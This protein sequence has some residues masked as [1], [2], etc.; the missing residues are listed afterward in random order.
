MAGFASGFAWLTLGM[1]FTEA[2]RLGWR[3]GV[4]R[5]DQDR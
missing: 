2:W 4:R 1:V 3:P 5:L